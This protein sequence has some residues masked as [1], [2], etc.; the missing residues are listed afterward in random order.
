MKFNYIIISML[1][2]TASSLNA[3]AEMPPAP[4]CEISSDR[5]STLIS[6]RREN[7]NGIAGANS[8]DNIIWL[9]HG[10][11]IE[12]VRK[13]Y[14][15]RLAP[16]SV[17]DARVSAGVDMARGQ[18]N[19]G[20]FM[21]KDCLFIA[22]ISADTPVAD[23][24]LYKVNVPSAADTTREPL[25]SERYPIAYELSEGEEAPDALSLAVHPS[26]GSLYI[27]THEADEARIFEAAAPKATGDTLTFRAIG[28]IGLDRPTSADFSPDG[29]FLLVRNATDAIEFK[30]EGNS[31]TAAS[32]ESGERMTL[33]QETGGNSI[34]Y[35]A[36]NLPSY[37]YS[38]NLP[39]K[40]I[41][42]FEVYTASA[43]AQPLWRYAYTESCRSSPTS[44][45]P[46]MNQ[47][48]AGS[49]SSGDESGCTSAGGGAASDLIWALPLM[50]GAA[51][52]R[53]SKRGHL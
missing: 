37:N 5:M 26:T 24:A 14:A 18:C 46:S 30:L 20:E 29:V 40:D 48:N 6:L 17:A 23:R 39:N 1:I 15:A 19:P 52:R 41:A 51:R 2:I 49:S 7:V 27:I 53:R 4:L 28:K 44:E 8:S 3:A 10:V 36:L 35:A 42:P 34:T 22:D 12:V 43:D 45:P 9:H 38:N 11:M 16:W 13:N 47:P 25:A 50:F 21:G 32:L 31:I 33:E